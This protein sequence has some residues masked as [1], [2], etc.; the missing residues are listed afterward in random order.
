M[1]QKC[2]GIIFVGKNFGKFFRVGQFESPF[3]A[4]SEAQKPT[5]I[6]LLPINIKKERTYIIS[7]LFPLHNPLPKTSLNKRGNI[8]CCY[9]YFFVA[10]SAFN[11][12]L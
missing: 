3:C 8:I 9:S 2:Y 1:K 11:F 12:W 4:I 5:P 6:F 10:L 7:S